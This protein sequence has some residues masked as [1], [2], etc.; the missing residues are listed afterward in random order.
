MVDSAN[1]EPTLRAEVTALADGRYHW[2]VL[3]QV[4]PLKLVIRA[5]SSEPLADEAA[6]RAAAEA[7][8]DR[9]LAGQKPLQPPP[10]DEP[11]A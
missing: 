9:L 5:E 10:P 4:A 8:R 3:E 6:A 2:L 7:E 11:L 1:A